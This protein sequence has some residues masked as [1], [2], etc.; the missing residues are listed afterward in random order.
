MISRFFFVFFTFTEIKCLVLKRF[1]LRTFQ[2]MMHNMP[3][4][5]YLRTLIAEVIVALLTGSM[6]VT[7]EVSVFKSNTASLAS[8]PAST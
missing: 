1:E 6:T 7:S 4:F 2:N 8:A 3:L 5:V